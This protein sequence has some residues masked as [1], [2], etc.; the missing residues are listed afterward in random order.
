MCVLKLFVGTVGSCQRM[1]YCVQ[2]YLLIW[3]QISRYGRRVE[4]GWCVK[5]WACAGPRPAPPHWVRCCYRGDSAAARAAAVKQ[6][7]PRCDGGGQQQQQQDHH[8]YSPG[9]CSTVRR[10]PAPSPPSCSHQ[11]LGITCACVK[12]PPAAQTEGWHQNNS[13][14]L[15]DKEDALGLV[16]INPKS[17]LWIYDLKKIFV[18]WKHTR[19]YV[20]ILFSAKSWCKSKFIRRQTPNTQSSHH[21][22]CHAPSRNW[23]ILFKKPGENWISKI[24]STIIHHRISIYT[25]YISAFVKTKYFW[26]SIKPY[27]QVWDN[28]T[29]K[30]KCY[31]KVYKN[32][33]NSIFRH[34][35]N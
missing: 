19:V 2:I 6:W 27:L 25:I 17:Q 16:K 31:N 22:G 7:T 9:H 20:C 10:F 34:N 3:P 33:Y 13:P 12:Y 4:G 29:L 15:A 23:M 35:I 30:I 14:R 1:Y 26:I 18:F 11:K 21:S 28:H 32:N 24:L 8:H 5:V